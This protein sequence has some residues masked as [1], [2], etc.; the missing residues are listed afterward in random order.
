[1]CN[2][3]KASA[4]V[5][6]VDQLNQGPAT[7]SNEKV[8]TGTTEKDKPKRT[9]SSLRVPIKKQQNTNTTGVN[10][11]DETTGLNIPV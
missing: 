2:V 8:A 10:T 4:P 1:M 3:P 6:P 11:S 7:L 5:M 9:V